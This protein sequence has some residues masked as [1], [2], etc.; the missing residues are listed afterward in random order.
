MH[1][2]D[3]VGLAGVVQ[4]ALTG[5]GLLCNNNVDNRE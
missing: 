3:L 5:G 2:S 1:L 4:D